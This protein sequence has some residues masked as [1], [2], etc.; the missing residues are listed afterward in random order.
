MRNKLIVRQYGN[1]RNDRRIKRRQEFCRKSTWISYLKSTTSDLIWIL[2]RLF[3]G[4]NAFENLL[5]DGSDF[6]R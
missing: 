6:S 5:F 4:K 1:S 3:R 2:S